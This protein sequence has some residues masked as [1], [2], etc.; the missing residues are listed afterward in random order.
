MKKYL[1]RPVCLIL[2]LVVLTGALTAAALVGSPYDTLKKSLLD[3]A[4]ATSGSYKANMKLYV[5]GKL[6][7][8]NSDQTTQQ[9]S[10]NASLTMNKNGIFSFDG[11][12]FS[13]YPTGY[14]TED[15]EQWYAIYR[16]PD[17]Y[18][19]NYSLTGSISRDDTAVR[20]VELAADFLVGDLKN[21]ISISEHDGIKT[22]SGTLTAGQIPELYNAGLS[23]MA[24]SQSS[25]N[26]LPTKTI[27]E[28]DTKW[29]YEE[30]YLNGKTKTVQ[31]WEVE[32]ETEL[33]K[34]SFRKQYGY[35][36]EKEYAD[37]LDGIANGNLYRVETNRK[38]V[39]EKTEEAT[40]GDYE[41][42]L[43]QPMESAAI[44]YMSGTAHVNKEGYLTDMS[45]TARFMVT[46]IFGETHEIEVVVDVVCENMGSTVVECPIPGIDGIFTA[47]LFESFYSTGDEYSKDYSY[48]GYYGNLYFRLN[49]DGTVDQSS[50][51]TEY[52]YETTV[53][54]EVPEGA[55]DLPVYVD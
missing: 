31:V 39:S 52:E 40:A 38:L 23:L 36:D 11:N 53:G 49:A 45:A 10:E 25:S 5:D 22:L 2:S 19:P 26:Y 50:I 15:N 6:L 48:N 46:T 8:D 55:P 4:F 16:K 35:F 20:F 12:R 34:E 3:T 14:Y 30:T 13:I 28:T 44:D 42:V 43:D 17:G 33:T 1:T 18:E 29:V 32:Y 51:T 24:V 21:N 47:E 54:V 41:N 27:S 9:F 37:M 7:E